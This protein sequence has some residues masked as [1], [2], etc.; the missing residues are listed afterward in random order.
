MNDPNSFEGLTP[1][2]I[3]VVGVILSVG[4]AMIGMLAAFMVRQNR[5]NSDQFTLLNKIIT[6]TKVLE[7]R[8]DSHE[9]RITRIEDHF[10]AGPSEN[11]D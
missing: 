11:T 4:I 9:V 6:Q 5:A 3:T 1:G 8:V 7:T 10:I 2:A